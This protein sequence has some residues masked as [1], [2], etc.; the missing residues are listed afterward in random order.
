MKDLSRYRREFP[1]TENHVYM[2]HAA[3]SPPPLRVLES[4][5]ALSREFTYRG[6][7]CYRAWM[8]R[9]AQVRS[10]VASL[11]NC[12]DH[13]VAFVQNTS[14]GLSNVAA[15]LEWKSGDV[16]LVPAPDFPANI[17]PWMNLKARGVAVRFIQRNGRRF[18]IREIEKA[19]SPGTRLLSVS[20]V[21]FSTGFLCD[22]EA[23][24]DFCRRKG[25]LFCVDGIQSL[26]VIPM[27]VKKF[28]IHFLASGSHKWLLGTMG[29]G[30][31]Y[32]ADEVNDIIRPSQVGWKSVKDEEDFF[33]IGLDLKPDALRFEPG[34]MNV[35]GIYALGAA[36]EKGLY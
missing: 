25:I 34:T 19:L 5:E 31:L 9:V 15:G 27:D 21:D 36:L 26:G 33:R 14:T 30:F 23:M 13:E 16:V 24:G 32:I 22:L 35:A 28:Q 29:C 17:Y 8:E 3:I 18:G 6:I 11:I 20:S 10:L 4:V 12:R 7:E 2:N 1:I